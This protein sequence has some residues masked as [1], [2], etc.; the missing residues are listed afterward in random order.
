MSTVQDPRKTWLATGSLLPVWWRMPFLGPKLSLAFWLWLLP[1]C[2]SALLWYSLNRLFCEQARLCLRLELFM[3]KA[4]STSFFIF[5]LSGYPTV[6]V[7]ISHQ[8]PQIVP[9]HSGPVL[10][11]SMQPSPSVQPLLTGDGHE[12][13]GYFFAGS[14]G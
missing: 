11:L 1:S 4:L 10:T 14:C 3:G 12:H 2:L 5:S 7:A 6:W 8:L 13:L 9:G